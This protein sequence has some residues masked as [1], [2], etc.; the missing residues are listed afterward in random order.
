MFS[1]NVGKIDRLIRIVVGV[2][3]LAGFVLNA[4]ASYRWLYLIGIVPLAT[5]LMNSCALYSIFGIN[6][7]K[8]KK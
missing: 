1:K 6:T 5:G 4:E 8:L 2:A 3:L 7:C